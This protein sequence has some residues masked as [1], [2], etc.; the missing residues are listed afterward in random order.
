[1]CL[2]QTVNPSILRDREAKTAATLREIDSHLQRLQAAKYEREVALARIR[3]QLVLCSELAALDP[4][5][6]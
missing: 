1:M 5:E 4:C 2:H 6:S 3:A